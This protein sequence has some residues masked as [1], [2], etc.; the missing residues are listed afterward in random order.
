MILFFTDFDDDNIFIILISTYLQYKL[1]IQLY[2]AT[3]HSSSASTTSNSF[4]ATDYNLSNKS[5]KPQLI[6]HILEALS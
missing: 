4:S 1:V 3:T 2:L 6:W 5:N